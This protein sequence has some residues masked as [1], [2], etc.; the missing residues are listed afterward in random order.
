MLFGCNLSGTSDNNFSFN[1]FNPLKDFESFS[2][3]IEEN[4][5]ENRTLSEAISDNI[6]LLEQDEDQW[7]LKILKNCSF[8]S[9]KKFPVII[10]M[11]GGGGAGDTASNNV[12]YHTDGE[13]QSHL[14]HWDVSGGQGGFGGY[15]KKFNH[16]LLRNKIYNCYIGNGGTIDNK[17]GADTVIK[18]QNNQQIEIAYGGEGG[19]KSQRLKDANYSKG[20]GGAGGYAYRNFYL[21]GGAST[22]NAEAGED[23]FEFHSYLYGAGGGGGS[24]P[25]ISGNSSSGYFVHTNSN[26]NG[27]KNGGGA[28]AC[29]TNHNYVIDTNGEAGLLNS[30][31]GGGG[32]CVTDGEE[33]NL[34]GNGGSGI[35]I[36]SNYN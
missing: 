5:F 1:I 8:Y 9:K 6:C 27:G 35:I 18:D 36:I 26:G 22:E 20:E 7:S 11:V 32:G 21:E 30:G 19:D 34:P 10:F 28:G 25:T 31:S 14:T 24:A 4:F 3:S 15:A 29:F 2:Y 17:D 16:T 13:N 12:E 23:G 33:I